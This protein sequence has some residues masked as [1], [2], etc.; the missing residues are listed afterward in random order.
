MRLSSN[1]RPLLHVF[2]NVREEDLDSLLVE[3]VAEKTKVATKYGL[4]NFHGMS[5][6]QKTALINLLFI[7]TFKSAISNCQLSTPGVTCC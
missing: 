6:S 4:K 2:K 3:A 5:R 1:W 7:E